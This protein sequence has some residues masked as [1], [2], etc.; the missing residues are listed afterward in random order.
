[1]IRIVK[2]KSKCSNFQA[3][4]FVYSKF[5][6]TFAAKVQIFDKKGTLSPLLLSYSKD[7]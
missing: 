7:D 4:N 1:M 5:I 3:N 6:F 2:D